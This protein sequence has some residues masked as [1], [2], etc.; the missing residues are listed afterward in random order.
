MRNAA[1]WAHVQQHEQVVD[2][3]ISPNSRGPKLNGRCTNA[4]GNYISQRIWTRNVPLGRFINGKIRIKLH[5][6]FHQF[7]SIWDQ[8]GEPIRI[9]S[10]M[11]NSFEWIEF[12]GD[13]I[14]LGKDIAN[15]IEKKKTIGTL[16]I[17]IVTKIN[18]AQY[19]LHT[20]FI[21]GKVIKNAMRSLV[22]GTQHFHFTVDFD[23]QSI[24]RNAAVTMEKVIRWNDECTRNSQRYKAVAEHRTVALGCRS[25]E[26]YL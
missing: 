25:S 12:D 19:L 23:R 7:H 26:I 9:D 15:D 24:S 3:W 20:V 16:Y 18:D 5:V 11:R 6:E 1:D 8:S 22:L 10:Y 4:D 13:R 17:S 2:W 21:C 14:F